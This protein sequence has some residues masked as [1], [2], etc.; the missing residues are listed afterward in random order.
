MKTTRLS[1]GWL[2]LAGAIV[3]LELLFIYEAMIA[4]LADYQRIFG[5]FA[6]LA[7]LCFSA[8]LFSVSETMYGWGEK[9]EN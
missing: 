6:G 1:S 2:V 4:D 5:V 9:E 3:A 7:I 8:L